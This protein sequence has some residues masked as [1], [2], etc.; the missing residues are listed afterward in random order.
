MVILYVRT[1]EKYSNWW[2][3]NLK[4]MLYN[5]CENGD[6]LD[7]RGIEKGEGSVYDKLFLF[8]NFK[9]NE[10]YLY[11]DLDVVIKS[12]ISHLIRNDFTLLNAWWRLPAHTPL[13][14]SIMSWYGDHSYI[15][16]KFYQ[17]EDYYRVK[18]WRGI[19]EYIFK[20]IDYKIY[21]KVCWSWMFDKNELEYPV[22]IFNQSHE[23]I[24]SS[25]WVKKYILENKI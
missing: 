10:Q 1:G 24:H 3:D 4:F 19:D 7:I 2:L 15:Y 17:D 11:F 9:D 5:H 23:E 12:D 20:E 16:D 21:D 18:Y 25:E 8:K 13:N 6:K 22:C 14:S